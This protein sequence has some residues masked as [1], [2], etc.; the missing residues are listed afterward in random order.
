MRSLLGALF[1]KTPVPY[2]PAGTSPN[3]G[4]LGLFGGARGATAQMRSMGEVGTLFAIVSRTANATSQVDWKLWRKAA[5]GK[6]EDRTEVTSHAAV[7]L[8]QQPNK[9]MTRQELVEA[10]QQHVDLTGEGWC[11]IGRNPRF[12]N[13]PLELWPVRPDRMAPV[14]SRDD[15]IQGYMYTSPDGEAVPL[16]VDDVLMLRM[17]NPL[18]PYRGMGPVQSIL[19]NIDS[20]KYSAEWNR[21]FFLNSAQ[22]GGIIEVDKR[23]SNDEWVEMTTRWREQHQGVANAHRVAVLEQGKWVNAQYSMR[24]M[25]FAELREVSRDT[26]LEAFGFPKFMLGAVDDVNRANAEASAAMFA[27]WLVRPR[28]E[29]WKGMLNNDL[30]PLFGATAKG[31]E[32]DYEDPV[33]PN[34]EAENAARNSR[35]DAVAKLIPLGFDAAQAMESFGLPPIKFEKPEPPPPPA[36]PPAPV[37]EEPA[38]DAPAVPPAAEDDAVKNL[39]RAVLAL[40]EGRAR[41]RDDDRSPGGRTFLDWWS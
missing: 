35:V 9:Y 7:D 6:K 25:Q 22:P 34:S 40:A 1:N 12:R 5:S 11:V 24:D 20:A 10:G 28:L 3:V 13:L 29:R 30:L 33:P 37:G 27:Q 39:T 21:N 19:T 8:W 26:M 4:F 18:D 36:P 16:Q 32:F 23:L 17:P 14:P 31:L 15:F 41:H 2:A 38:A